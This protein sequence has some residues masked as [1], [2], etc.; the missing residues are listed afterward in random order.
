MMHGLT[1]LTMRHT[2]CAGVDE[3]ERGQLL[4]L[5]LENVALG[6]CILHCS[7]MSVSHFIQIGKGSLT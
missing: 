7:G 2:D 5:M 3:K 1:T 6:C 4:L